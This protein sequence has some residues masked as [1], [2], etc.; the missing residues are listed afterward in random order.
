MHETSQAPELQYRLGTPDAE[1]RY[2]VIVGDA[3]IGWAFRWHRDWLVDSSA[4]ERN[5]HRPP[6]GS[7]G[8]DMAAD[9]LAGEFR[10][11]RITATPLAE[12]RAE[13]A[14]PHGPAPLLHPRMPIT[15]ANV[16]AAHKA[17]AGLTEHRWTPRSGYPGADNPWFVVC[18]LCGW[19]GPRYWSHL[20]GRNGNPPSIMR[21]EGGCIGADAV[22]QTIAAYQK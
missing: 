13:S 2:P 14:Q 9:Y 17:L 21:H 16:R 4:G 7:K 11:G 18:D 6:K 22:R 12:A 15:T 1:C 8:V 19:S 3:L 10:A 5:L 20:R